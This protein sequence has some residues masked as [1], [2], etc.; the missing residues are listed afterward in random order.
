MDCET[1]VVDWILDPLPESDRDLFQTATREDG[2]HAKS[3]FKSL[4][5]T[6]MD[7][8]DDV[9]YG[10]HDLEDAIACSSSPGMPSR[11]R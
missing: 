9:S 8:A 11:R 2:K 10:V 1:D 5:C 3:L 7:V 6:I 4:D